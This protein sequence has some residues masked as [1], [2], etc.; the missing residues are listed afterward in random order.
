MLR[1]R[2][3][4]VILCTP[5]PYFEYSE[6]EVEPLHG[7]YALMLGYA[8]FVRDFAKEKG[9][10]LCDYHSYI[11]E[12]SQTETIVNPDHVHPNSDGHYYMAKCFL[13]F[14]G[15]ELGENRE[16]PKFLDTWREKIAKIRDILA[17][18]HHVIKDRSLTPEECVD[19]AKWFIEN[20]E[21]N[22]YKEYFSSLC[23]KYIVLKPMQAQL[24][25]EA[26]KLMDNIYEK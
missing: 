26:D 4:E 1:D 15:F 2:G 22:R 10:K 19:K 23:E 17:T 20:G 12:I 21:N 3:V 16:I 6:S 11:T 18:E 13:K 24:E 25:K 14:Q 7:G 9:I 8:E 5:T